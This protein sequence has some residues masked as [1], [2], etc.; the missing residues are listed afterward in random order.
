MGQP[1]AATNGLGNCYMQVVCESASGRVVFGMSN[2][3][4]PCLIVNPFLVTAVA[5]LGF[6]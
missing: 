1:C 5:L 3:S 2:D 6:R 4:V